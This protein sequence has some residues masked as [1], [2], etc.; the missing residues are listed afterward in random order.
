MKE[1]LILFLFLFM[2]LM[3]NSE[4]HIPGGNVSGSWTYQ[5][6]PYIIEGYISILVNDELTIE[7]GVEI[8]F[9]GHYKF[10]VY[11]KLCAEGT[12]NDTI[13]FTTQD[14]ING[15]Y[16]LRF[17]DT[18]SNGQD[19]SILR[20]CLFEYGNALTGNEE[21]NRGGALSCSYSSNIQI[22]NCRFSNN[23]ADYGGAIALMESDINM[24]NCI[25]ENNYASHDAG[26]MMI[27]GTSCVPE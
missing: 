25:I 4:T 1:K 15:W 12:I 26:G 3:L 2:I 8:I 6:Q 5:N 20:Y 10:N 7:P 16:G 9:Q 23:Q 22:I 18:S 24:Q 21:N 17:S 11:G 27:S 13:V 19:N 14:H